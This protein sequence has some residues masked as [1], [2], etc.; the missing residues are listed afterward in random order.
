MTLCENME[1][2]LSVIYSIFYFANF[3][4]Y[5]LKFY[6]NKNLSFNLNDAVR[7]CSIFSGKK[8]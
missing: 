4:L 5:K 2:G 7:R 1:Y 3:A 8:L 6:E